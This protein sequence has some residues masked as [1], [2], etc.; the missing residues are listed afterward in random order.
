MNT[1]KMLPTLLFVMLLSVTLM[2]CDSSSSTGNPG[3]GAASQPTTSTASNPPPSSGNSATAIPAASG[4]SATAN[5][6][7]SSGSGNGKLTLVKYVPLKL[8]SAAGDTYYIYMGIIRNDSNVTVSQPT[9]QL[10]DDSG[11]VNDGANESLLAEVIELPP[12]QSVGFNMMYFGAPIKNP[13]FKLTVDPTAGLASLYANMTVLSQKASTSADGHHMLTG[14]VKNDSAKSSD[15]WSVNVIAY[16]AS[17]N[18]VDTGKGNGANAGNANDS[19]IPFK[20]QSTQKFSVT[21][22]DLAGKA[23]RYDVFASGCTC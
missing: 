14:T 16:D 5:P 22:S 8:A 2:A 9:M 11:K 21:L 13:Q 20:A 17:G 6:A 4:N 7:A 15:L 19:G 1:R 3:S 18:V 23:T 10:I 12:G